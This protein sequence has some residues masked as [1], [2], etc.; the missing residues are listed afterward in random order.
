MSVVLLG[1]PRGTGDAVI[2]RLRSQGDEVRVIEA[3]P[4]QADRWRSLGAHV[5][6]G[7]VDDAD[8]IERAAQNARTIVL[9][10]IDDR[11]ADLLNAVITGASQTSVDRVILVTVGPA[12][13]CVELLRSSGLD[14]IVLHTPRR[15]AMFRRGEPAAE[16]VAEAVDAA[17][18]LAGHPRLELEVSH[19]AAARALGLNRI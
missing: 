8:L 11:M 1:P 18:D 2:Q 6:Y 13:A 14:Y 3:E 10:E 15:R 9:F 12:I 19:P 17:D 4:E 7:S 16:A 5:A